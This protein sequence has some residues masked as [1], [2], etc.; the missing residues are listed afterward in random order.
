MDKQTF[1]DRILETEN[2]TDN[3]E[4]DAADYLLKWGVGQ[5]EQI[6]AGVEDEV[7]AADKVSALM[8]LMR[9]VNRIVGNQPTPAPERVAELAM[10][11]AQAFGAEH[12]TTAANHNAIAAEAGTLSGVEAVKFLLDWVKKQ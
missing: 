1:I 10:H 4:D 9:G 2:L 11:Y 12:A 8:K 7:V 6:L 5:L 3:L